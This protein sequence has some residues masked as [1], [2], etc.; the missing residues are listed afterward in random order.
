LR[1]PILAE[2]AGGLSSTSTGTSGATTESAP[3]ILG[4]LREQVGPAVGRFFVTMLGMYLLGGIATAVGAAA[5]TAE[6]SNLSGL[7]RAVL[8]L[9]A[10]VV[11]G[12]AWAGGGIALGFVRASGIA[13]ADAILRAALGRRLGLAAGERLAEMALLAREGTSGATGGAAQGRAAS[14]VG[15]ALSGLE[16]L[17]LADAEGYL[18]RAIE[19]ILGEGAPPDGTLGRLRTAILRRIRGIA[20]RA[21]EAFLLAEFRKE[22]TASGHGGGVD[23]KK[24]IGRVAGMADER[25]SGLVRAKVQL[26]TIAALAALLLASALPFLI[27]LAVT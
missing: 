11:V 3:E 27:A 15:A 10:V 8:G 25:V 12:A 26:V 16:A 18:K 24:V 1:R 21:V 5:L 22:A 17:P 13:A 2:G 7:S 4:V 20:V 6:L 23:V 19:S 9:A 14:V